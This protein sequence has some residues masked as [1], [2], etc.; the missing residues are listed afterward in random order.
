MRLAAYC[1]TLEHTS[2]DAPYAEPMAGYV[3]LILEEYRIAEPVLRGLAEMFRS[4][5]D[6]ET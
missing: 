5:A 2:R 4:E 6:G 1:K 3:T